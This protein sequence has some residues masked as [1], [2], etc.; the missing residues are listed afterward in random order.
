MRVVVDGDIRTELE[1]SVA[2]TH[3]V[4]QKQ[5]VEV[6]VDWAVHLAFGVELLAH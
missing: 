1:A 5:T 6:L 3:T 2:L 4:E